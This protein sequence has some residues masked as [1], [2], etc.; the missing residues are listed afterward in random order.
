MPG[1]SLA[2]LVGSH[3]RLNEVYSQMVFHQIISGVGYLH[4]KGIVHLGLSCSKVLLMN[5]NAN[6]VLTGPWNMKS[7]DSDYAYR[8][9]L[10][11][12]LYDLELF[13]KEQGF[14]RRDECSIMRDDIVEDSLV[15]PWYS[16]PKTSHDR[17]YAKKKKRMSLAVGSYW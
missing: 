12:R 16:T 3:I 7:F 6:I 14:D 15:E 2:E 13:T 9:S 17:L 4:R 5:A 1:G 8:N 10:S 11:R